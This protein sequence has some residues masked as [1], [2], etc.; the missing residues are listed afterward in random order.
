[1]PDKHPNI[2]DPAATDGPGENSRNGARKRRDP[3]EP[4][5]V[6]GLGASA[7]GVAPLQQ[8]FGDMKPDTGLAFVVVMHLSPD[9]ESQLASVIQQKTTMPVTQVHEPVKV[10]PN[11]VYVIPP[12]HQLSFE[13]GMLGLV[14]LQH[15]L[16]RRITIDLFFRTLGQAYGQRSVCVILSGSDSDGVIGL[17]HVRAQGGLTIVQDPN[18]AEFDSMPATAISTGMVDWVLPVSQMAAKLVE[19]VENENAMRLPPEVPESDEPDA[20]VDDA[21]GGETVSDETRSTEDE[22]AIVKVLTDVRVQTGQD[23]SH[24]KRATVLRRIARRLQVNSLESIPEYLDFIRTH[25]A[26]ARALLQ[27][28]LIGVTHF[29]RDRDSFAVLESHIPQ[30][31]AGK[32][33]DEE[34]RVWVAGC[35]SGEEAYSIA[36]LLC[37]H[38]KRLDVPPR[39]QIFATD[40]DDEAIADARDGLYPPV[41]EADVSPERLREFF[42]RDH[43]RYRV[44]KEIREKVLFATHNL[45]RDAPFSRCDLISCRNLLIY[46]KGEAQKQV[47]DIFHFALRSTGLLFLGGAENDDH[48]LFSPLDAKHRIYVRRSI[49]RPS[50][51][52]PTVP[53]RAAGV[54]GR[55]PSTWRSR[56]LPALTH[57]AADGVAT[58][59]AAAVQAG[60]TR[61]EALFGELHLRLLEQYGAPSAVVNDAHEIVHLSESAGHYLQ[62]VAGEP[63]ANITKVVVPALQLEMRTALFKAA[64]TKETAISAAT[65]VE[66]GGST[67]VVTLEVRPMKAADEASGFYLVLF[68]NQSQHTAPAPA[69]PAAGISREADDEIQFLKEQLAATVEQ[70]EAS[71]EELKASNEELQAM[72]EEMRSATEELETSKEELQSV[73][74]ELITV[75]HELKANVEELSRTNADLSNLMAST[76]VGTIFLDR[77][78]RIHRFTPAAQKI[79]NLIPSDMGRPLSDITSAL[80]YD[81]FIRDVET[82]LH[83]LQTI[84]QEVRVGEEETWYLTRIAPYRTQD[85]RIAGVVATFIDINRRKRA[86]DELRESETRFRTLSETAP[87]LIWFNDSEGKNRY[88][89]RQY[90]EF[91][92]KSPEELAGMGWQL[93]LHP[94]DAQRVI[95]AYL[96]AVRE[97]RPFHDMARARRRDGEWRWLESFAQPL[98]DTAGTYLGHVGVSPDVTERR[99]A[100]EALRE[101]EERFRTVADN[102][103]QLIWTNDAEGYA[104]YFNRRWYEYSG[105]NYE[106]SAGL[107]WQ[108]IVHPEDEPASSERW[109]A[110][111]ARAE[112]FDCEYRLRS[113]DGTYRWFLARNVPL[114]GPN[115]KVIS[116]FGSAADIDDSKRAQRAR[117]ETEERF[118]LLVEGARDYAMFLLDLDNRITFWSNGAER[119]FGWSP[120][121]AEG[122]TGALIFVREDKAKGEFEKEI[123]TAM[124]EG[125]APD[126]RWHLRKDGS[127]L[128][129]DGVLMRLDEADGSPRGFAK[130]A[131]DATKQRED[132]EAL[133]HARDQLEQRV[134]ERTAEL[135]E[136]NRR[137]RKEAERRAKLESQILEVT[138]RERARISQDLHD[139]LCQ[140]LTATA[141]LLKSHAKTVAK[142]NAIAA[143][144][145]REAAVTVNANAGLARDLARGLHPPELGTGGLVSALREL[146]SRTNEKKMRC[147]CD[148][149][150]ALRV[151]DEQI[152][153]NLYRIAQE[154][155]VNATK[156]ANATEIVICIEREKNEIVLAVSDDGKRKTR[157]ANSSGL[158]IHMM[159]YRA[160]VCGGSLAIEPRRPR[161]TKVICRIPAHS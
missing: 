3:N 106:Q 114:R 93:I 61:R 102:V 27:D 36:I 41:I 126:R 65:E 103:P 57:D 47:F 130:I 37:E 66:I 125:R 135:I 2:L 77:Q 48:S 20:K 7:G 117:E 78:L 96:V 26:E 51:N 80:K 46:L 40:L 122:E 12:T 56:P 79:F 120:A 156:H 150:R 42:A 138:E 134:L 83:D 94:D 95:D 58:T 141:F 91:A 142:D 89:N 132:E 148:C 119:L 71:S 33:K 143:E 99:Q 23:F 6:I 15:A 110:A 158:G 29:F 73:N 153:V 75:N 19:F 60:H 116:W 70:Y 68:N 31:F 109:Q 133:R 53:M 76:D 140:E 131:R 50:W 157:R 118:R 10:L 11:N 25:A 18:E 30:L 104:N 64:H 81:G 90:V 149:P 63:T 161:G 9:Y 74:E 105:L 22:E 112:V 69:A 82:V 4:A 72:N 139:S 54:P 98:F 136:S 85:D 147:R 121:E 67:G 146:A 38:A 107:G 87:A 45:L 21:P 1:M 101:S 39:I 43:G 100:E 115:G 35:A 113:A 155:V 24:Y 17:K 152:A 88:I 34:L 8:F 13:D 129:V 5:A 108:A 159:Q 123:G 52:L 144:A 62:F 49:P 92:G 154:A 84:E 137:L 151:P 32:K 55:R 28:L 86:E 160:S 128:W 59:A 127:R 97:Q 111:Q 16:G 44:R 14:P 124:Q 145:M